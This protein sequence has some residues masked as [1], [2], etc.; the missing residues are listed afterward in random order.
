M[1]N[2][3]TSLVSSARWESDS[4]VQLTPDRS[5][6]G[7]ITKSPKGQ[8]TSRFSW[9]NRNGIQK[10]RGRDRQSSVNS[11]TVDAHL[12]VPNRKQ[13][14]IIAWSHCFMRRLTKQKFL[15]RTIPSRYNLEQSD[16]SVP[17]MQHDPRG[18]V[19]RYRASYGYP[20]SIAEITIVRI[21]FVGKSCR[22]CLCRSIFDCDSFLKFGKRKIHFC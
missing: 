11:S 17:I 4:E 8:S 3:I 22:I 18:I 15:T 20:L 7:R 14:S 10:D 12:D 9:G 21:K 2:G 1:R 6:T 19:S 16:V 5:G 13:M